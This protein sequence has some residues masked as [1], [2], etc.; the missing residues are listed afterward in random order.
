MRDS[1]ANC[2]KRVCLPFFSGKNPSNTNLSLGKPLFTKAGTKAVAPGKHSTG[3]WFSI[4]ARVSKNPGSEI[5]GVPASEIKAM[6]SPAFNRLRQFSMVLCSLCMWWLCMCVPMSKC[7]SNFALVRVS[8]AKIKSASLS[9]RMARNVISS[10]LP[11]GVGTIY[12]FD[13]KAK[14]Y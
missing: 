6:V 8:S 9:T 14:G 2:K 7:L 1:S 3:I 11:M 5:A 13:M 12:N 4:Q 10:R